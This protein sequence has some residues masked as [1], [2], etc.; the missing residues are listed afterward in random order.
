MI[1]IYFSSIQIKMV[2]QPSCSNRN[3]KTLNSKLTVHVPYV[4]N[5]PYTVYSVQYSTSV[6]YSAYQQTDSTGTCID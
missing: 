3:P 2:F 1:P 6:Q 4:R 5:R